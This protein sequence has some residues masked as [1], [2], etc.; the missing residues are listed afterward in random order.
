M[1]EKQAYEKKL[2]AHIDEWNAEIAKL[3]ARAD[4]ADAEARIEYQRRAADLKARQEAIGAKLDELRKRGEDAWGDIR[5][6]I[7]SAAKELQEALNSAS[8][9]LK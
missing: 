7:D 1:S 2:Q 3:K 5:S 9:K 6:G 8:S 4:R